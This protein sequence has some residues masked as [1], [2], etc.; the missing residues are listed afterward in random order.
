MKKR[1][2]AI[3]LAIIFCVGGVIGSLMLTDDTNADSKAKAEKETVVVVEDEDTVDDE[4]KDEEAVSDENK[5]ASKGI[6][7]AEKKDTVK[8]DTKKDTTVKKDTSKKETVKKEDSNKNDSKPAKKEESNKSNTESKPKHTHS[9]TA[10]YKEVDNGY[11]KT[12][13][14][15]V[16]YYICSKC[17]TD[18]SGNS[19]NHHYEVH[20]KN[21]EYGTRTVSA[22]RTVESQEWVP[23][24]EKVVDYYKC[25][26]GAT[27]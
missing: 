2:W 6:A 20:A 26:C 8:S 25:S 13:T 3:A 17:K 19:S 10:V 16:K 15:Q 18:I 7:T 11:Y 12:V 24:I 14:N 27:K 4:A 22:Y 23:K 1:I 5:E 21:G 9:W